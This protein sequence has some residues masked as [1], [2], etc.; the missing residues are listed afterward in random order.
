MGTGDLAGYWWYTV[1]NW[2]CVYVYDVFQR[3][4]YLASLRS[5]W[6]FPRNEDSLEV[7]DEEEIMLNYSLNG[8][9]EDQ[10]NC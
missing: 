10:G 8:L 4:L 3:C 1:H 2:W 5:L 9:E 7:G 6:F